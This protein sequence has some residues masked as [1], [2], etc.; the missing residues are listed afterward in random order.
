[1]GKGVSVTNNGILAKRGY[2]T[3]AWALVIITLAGGCDAN[4]QNAI[5][6]VTKPDVAK[7]AAAVAQKV[8][9]AP[10]SPDPALPR[11]GINLN[12][13]ADWNSELPFVDVFRLSRE[14]I[15]QREGAG[16]GQGPKLELDEHG[17]VKKLEPTTFA[18]TP[19]G[20]VSRSPAGPFTGYYKGKGKLDVGGM[21]AKLKASPVR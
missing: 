2:F 7:P 19:N 6:G 9:A 12:G 10:A 15:S 18:E 11:A 1:V 21:R 16:W 5:T 20:T 4:A 3:H 17:W 14:W 13:P 8:A